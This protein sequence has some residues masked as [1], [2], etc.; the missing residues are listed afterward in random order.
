MKQHNLCYFFVESAGEDVA[1]T[2]LNLSFAP[3]QERVCVAPNII[4]NDVAEEQKQLLLMLERTADL[5][6]RIATS[7]LTPPLLI[8]DDDGIAM[9]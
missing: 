1:N 8:I 3:C 9:S 4:S 7:N 2:S 5:D 6:Q